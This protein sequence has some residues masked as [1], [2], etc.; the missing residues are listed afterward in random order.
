VTTEY[1]PLAWLSANLNL[2]LDL[3]D[4]HDND[5][6]A[7]GDLPIGGAYNLG[8]RQSSRSNTHLW[9]GGCRA[10]HRST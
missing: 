4:R 3:P 8:F 1:R 9:T 6:V 5:D 7:A 2:G 10:R